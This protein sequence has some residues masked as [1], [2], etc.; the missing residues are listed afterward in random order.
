MKNGSREEVKTKTECRVK[1]DESNTPLTS[2]CNYL[3]RTTCHHN[4]N[5]RSSAK[6]RPYK[7]HSGHKRPEKRPCEGFLV[8]QSKSRSILTA[9]THAEAQA[10]IRD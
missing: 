3:D 10:E 4:E 2:S 1:A 6:K 9:K 7:T 8:W 5:K